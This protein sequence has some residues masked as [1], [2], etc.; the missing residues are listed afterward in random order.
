LP[1]FDFHCP[2][3]SL[4][5]V[6]KTTLET[7]PS[8][9]PYLTAHPDK[10]AAWGALLGERERPRIGLTWSGNSKTEHDFRRTISLETLTPILTDAVEWF[11]LQ[12][13]VRDR[14]RETLA[15]TP[16]LR[17]LTDRLTDF[18]DTAALISHMDL[19]ISA[20]TSVAHLVGALGKPLWLLL[21]FHPD[22]RWLRDR[23][24]SPWY[25]SA[26][27]FR[28]ARDGDWLDVVARV[29]QCLLEGDRH[30]SRSS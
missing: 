3:F 2:L 7:I 11:S 12:K 20:D 4:P 16:A 25:P 28:Q 22:F 5:L 14:D 27:L 15:R 30:G 8:S 19:V 26:T 29:T 9:F 24:D 21:P 18:S 6:L 17:D 1:P 23:S 13:D 10:V